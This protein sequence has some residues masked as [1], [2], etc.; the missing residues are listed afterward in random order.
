MGVDY[1]DANYQNVYNRA[2]LRP[3][4]DSVTVK[5]KPVAGTSSGVY[6]FNS[7]TV[8]IDAADNSIFRT[9]FANVPS[10]V[11][12]VLWQEHM[13]GDF[14]PGTAVNTGKIQY[15]A[16]AGGVHTLKLEMNL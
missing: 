3:L 13:S 9:S 10:E 4:G 7:Y 15:T 8:A 1:V 2:G 6:E 14:I 16:A 5:T 11:V 12:E